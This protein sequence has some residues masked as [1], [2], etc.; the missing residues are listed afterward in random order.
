MIWDQ[1]WWEPHNIIGYST[2]FHLYHWCKIS[3]IHIKFVD[4]YFIH[5]CDAKMFK[6]HDFKN[7]FHKS[8]FM[9]LIRNDMMMMMIVNAE[10][11]FSNFD[12]RVTC[13][14]IWNHC[15]ISQ[16]MISSGKNVGLSW[17]SW[18]CNK[19]RWM[20]WSSNWWFTRNFT[21]Q[22]QENLSIEQQMFRL[23]R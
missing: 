19:I 22:D 6:Y 7:W 4:Y 3:K 8:W 2:W 23:P 11:M 12:V 14:S 20:S 13:W 5:F 17:S 18:S 16:L 10:F 9:I 21:L 15:W 1:I